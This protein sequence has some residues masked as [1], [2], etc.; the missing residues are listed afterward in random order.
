MA[1]YPLALNYVQKFEIVDREFVRTLKTVLGDPSEDVL[2]G[3][4]KVNEIS[5][6]IKA[7]LQEEL[8]S[9]KVVSVDYDRETLR[10]LLR[11]KID[12][13]TEHDIVRRVKKI[14]PP[15]SIEEVLLS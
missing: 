1:V 13:K 10:Y 2:M 12:G 7:G 3:D 9:V 8:P 15:K 6:H 14:D 5:E 4:G 11:V